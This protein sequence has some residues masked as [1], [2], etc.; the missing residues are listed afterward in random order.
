MPIAAR[1]SGFTITLRQPRTVLL[2]LLG[3]ALYYR[4]SSGWLAKK[5]VPLVGDA[6]LKVYPGAHHGIA[7]PYQQAFDRDLLDFISS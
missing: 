2:D 7:G 5:T 1:R 6:E 4:Q 3:V